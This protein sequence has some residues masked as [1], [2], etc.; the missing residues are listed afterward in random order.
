MLTPRERYLID[1]L[2]HTLVETI[3]QTIEKCQFTPS[4]L[5]DAVMLA[6]IMHEER[7][8]SPG[9]LMDMGKCPVGE[10][11]NIP[12]NEII[13]A[14]IERRMEAGKEPILN[15]VNRIRSKIIK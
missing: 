1:P 9:W 4:E 5:R 15:I 12:I 14:E 8:T 11:G 10:T 13:G 3:Y 2:F 6:A 7:N